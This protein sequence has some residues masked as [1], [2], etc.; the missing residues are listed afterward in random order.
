MSD[1]L[2]ALAADLTRASS[3]AQ[4]KA[5]MAIRKSAHDL[6]ARAQQLAPVDTGA[7]KNSIGVD[8]S[9]GALEAVIGPTVNYA[10]YV[11]YGTRSMAPQPYMAPA[12]DQVI[13]TLT[14]ALEQLGGDIL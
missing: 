1:D 10:P 7:L 6:Q 4:R 9:M 13:P 12:A 8:L 2:A 11:E 5:G 3:D 14:Q